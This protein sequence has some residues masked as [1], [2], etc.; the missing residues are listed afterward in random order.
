MNGI[1]RNLRIRTFPLELLLSDIP[2]WA[3]ANVQKK[4]TKMFFVISPSKLQIPIIFGTPFT[5]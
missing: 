2:S 4:E 5:E 3:T 1:E